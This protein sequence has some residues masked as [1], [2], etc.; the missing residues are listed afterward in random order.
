PP[1]SMSAL[2][3]SPLPGISS[4]LVTATAWVGDRASQDPHRWRRLPAPASRLFYS[5]W[6][7]EPGSSR[8]PCTRQLTRGPGSGAPLRFVLFSC[9]PR[10]EPFTRPARTTCAPARTTHV[11]DGASAPPQARH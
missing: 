11:N 4:R 8:R 1:R 6:E 9:F 7:A 2:L 3:R 10:E 5:L